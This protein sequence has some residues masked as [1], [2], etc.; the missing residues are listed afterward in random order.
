VS[1]HV[2]NQQSLL[3]NFLLAHS[4]THVSPLTRKHSQLDFSYVYIYVEMT[5]LD[6]VASILPSVPFLPPA[7]PTKDGKQ[8]N[9]KTQTGAFSR[10]LGTSAQPKSTDRKTVPEQAESE[11]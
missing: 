4:Q 1:L 9:K 6:T 3:P 11:R 8:G 2:N 10:F 5:L 7:A